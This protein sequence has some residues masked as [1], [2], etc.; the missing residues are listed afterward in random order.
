LNEIVLDAIEVYAKVLRFILIE[1][2]E[3]VGNIAEKYNLLFKKQKIEHLNILR[4]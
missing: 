1:P 4:R 3:S 2:N